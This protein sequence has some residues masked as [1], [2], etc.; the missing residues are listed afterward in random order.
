M[1]SPSSA[2]TETVGHIDLEK[3][4]TPPY[5]VVNPK[6]QG[7]G[8]EED[9]FVV[10][11]DSPY[12]AENP[13]TWPTLRKALMTAQLS[14]G[15]FAVT[16]CSSTYSGAI[17]DMM[18]DLHMSEEVAV[19][20]LSAYVIGFGLGPLLFAPLSEMYGRQPVFLTTYA[21][22]VIFH[23]GCALAQNPQTM[24]LCR[25]FAG[26]FGSAPLTNSGGM[27]SDLFAPYE[28]AVPQTLYGTAPLLGPV[29]GPIL[30]GYVS[31]SASLGWRWLFGIQAIITGLN[32]LAAFI[33]FPET[34]SPVILQRRAH[35]LQKE[36]AA[37]A[38]GT[39]A[40]PQYFVDIF[41]LN[42]KM[43]TTLAGKLYIGLSRPFVFLMQEPIVIVLA[44]YSAIFYST[45]YAFFAGFSKVFEKG[46]H[47]SQGENGLAFL[48]IGL[49]VLIGVFLTPIQT[50]L[51]R[52]HGQK[53]PGPDGNP[54]PE[55]RMILP[56]AAA[57]LLPI[58]IFWFAWT[59]S[60]RIHWILPIV[61]ATP[62]GL[63]MA[64][65]MIAITAYLMDSYG[66][67]C[68][69]AIAAVVVTRSVCAAAFP[70]FTP[71]LLRNLGTEWGLSIFGL[72][73]LL[74]SPLPFLLY[75][76]GP[77]LRARS[78]YATEVAGKTYK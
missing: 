46:H 15:T 76:Y 25:F 73:S 13:R 39:S 33:Y 8:T 62:F 43:A 7:S 23:I 11:W 9:P 51:Y 29:V 45:L 16:C 67:M 49:G 5:E 22:F 75:K 34:F 32:L 30:G 59:S 69:S 1:T 31:Q 35:K 28:R 24:M 36:S 77:L 63:G 41:H 52:R 50:A 42:G 38:A 71:T 3:T 19:I 26:A 68:A 55:A 17:P 6:Y 14:F 65:L 27:I 20:G 61:G 37:Q 78:R 12:D 21:P 57:I 72:L 64:L 47:F 66:S 40:A 56:M 60:P 54:L 74:C 44:I 18:R 53:Q 58:G 4:L 70:L 48:G 2:E 10:V